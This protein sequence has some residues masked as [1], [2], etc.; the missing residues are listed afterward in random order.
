MELKEVRTILLKEWDPL[1]VGDNPN[2]ADEYES[3]LPELLKFL[4][5]HHSIHEI[6]DY[7][8]GIEN[9]FGITPPSA[10]RVKAAALLAGK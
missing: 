2:L 1:N 8:E 5:A 9:S 4:K 7:L 6:A 10:R 3:Y